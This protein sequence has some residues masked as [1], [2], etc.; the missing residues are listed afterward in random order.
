MDGT[1]A[2]ISPDQTTAL[3]APPERAFLSFDATYPGSNPLE[4][5]KVSVVT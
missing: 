5:V 1:A 3:A 4:R 2:K